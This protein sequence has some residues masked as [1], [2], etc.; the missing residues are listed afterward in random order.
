MSIF[1]LLNKFIPT[2]N[3]GIVMPW[4]CILL[5]ALLLTACISTPTKKPT[6][7]LAK[8][9]TGTHSLSVTE[10]QNYQRALDELDQ[11]NYTA[12]Q[13]VL[14]RLIKKNPA[15]AEPTANL[16]LVYYKTGDYAD[17]AT[18]AE[19]ALALMQD[20]GTDSPQ[21]YNLLGQIHMQV[22]DFTAAQEFL[23]Q[24]IELDAKYSNAYYNLGLLHDVFYQDI[25][26]AINY[27]ER[28]LE[29]TEYSDET[30]KGWVETLRY[31][32]NNPL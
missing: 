21:L 23:K 2:H 22:G 11:G 31:S 26:A 8:T 27:Y 5:S 10:Q 20:T 6:V 30:T 25:E 4:G 32:L 7:A 15:L 3:S 9:V 18:A 28:Y 16:A 17:A 14:E 29:L 13:D 1:A 24:A 19:I 12:A